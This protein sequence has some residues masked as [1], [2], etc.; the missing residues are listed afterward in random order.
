[1]SENYHFSPLETILHFFHANVKCLFTEQNTKLDVKPYHGFET[2]IFGL[3]TIKK[4]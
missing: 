3:N 1:M 2:N 4:P